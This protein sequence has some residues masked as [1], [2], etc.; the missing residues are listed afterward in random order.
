MQ[1][2]S[3]TSA[4]CCWTPCPFPTATPASYQLPLS[5]FQHAHHLQGPFPSPNTA[6]LILVSHRN[7]PFPGL[8]LRLPQ[9]LALLTPLLASQSRT[10][11]RPATS[12]TGMVSSPDGMPA[13][14]SSFPS[15]QP[16]ISHRNNELLHSLSPLGFLFYSPDDPSP[17]PSAII[18]KGSNPTPQLLSCC[19]VPGTIL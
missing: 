18:T 1:L 3:L 5:S 13:P 8:H 19:D 17:S 4:C 15:I 10:P 12:R 2:P 14:N 16:P 7:L 9:P 11:R 6:S